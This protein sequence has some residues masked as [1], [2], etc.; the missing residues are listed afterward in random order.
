MIEAVSARRREWFG[1]CQETVIVLSHVSSPSSDRLITCP[2]LALA[3]RPANLI[4]ASSGRQAASIW[5]TA[6]LASRRASELIAARVG[7]EASSEGVS[8]VSVADEIVTFE[9]G[10]KPLFRPM[11]YVSMAWAFDLSSYEEVKDHAAAI[12]DRLRDG[13]TPCDSEWPEEQVEQFQRRTE[14]GTQE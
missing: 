5:G 11:D 2:T 6:V 4:G 3:D 9:A 7:R 8:G 14:T 13:S 1:S 12:L 10:I